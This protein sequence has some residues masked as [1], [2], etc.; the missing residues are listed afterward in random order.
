MIELPIPDLGITNSASIEVDYPVSWRVSDVDADMQTIK[1]TWTSNE[2]GAGDTIVTGQSTGVY[3]ARFKSG[4]MK[5][6]TMQVEDK[7]GGI[8]VARYYYYVTPSKMVYV[9]PY[10]PYRSGPLSQISGQYA[11]ASGRGEGRVWSDGTV[12]VTDFEHKYRFGTSDTTAKL[13][14]WGYKNGQSD[15]GYLWS[16][17]MPWGPN[18]HRDHPV[19]ANGNLKAAS[20]SPE[21]TN[22]YYVYSDKSG[23]D[24]F[25]YAWVLCTKGE[26]SAVFVGTPLVAPLNPAAGDVAANYSLALPLEATDDE[27]NPVFQDSFVE[28]FFAKEKYASDN[29]GDMNGDGIPDY[30]ATKSW[31]DPSGAL[32]TLPEAQT[33]QS[34]S[35]SAGDA[36]S[37]SYP[38]DLAA[39]DGYNGDADFLPAAWGSANPL[40]PQT[41][42][43]GPGQKFTAIRE[44]RGFGN[45]LNEP[46][47][48][49]YDLTEAETNAL[50]AA[51]AAAGE[52]DFTYAA[53]TNWATRAGWTPEAIN[54]GT[55][56]RL[57][58]I[59]PDTDG[60]EFNDGWEYY[61]WYYAKIGAMVD[62]KWG[63]LEGRRLDIDGSSSRITPEE[64]AQA[65]DPHAARDM[66]GRFGMDFDNDGLTDL[67]E[68]VLG[69]NPCDWD[70]DGDG[71]SDLWEV[72][73][74]VDPCFADVDSNPD[75][76]FMARLDYQGDTF[77]LYAFANG[78]MYALP[79]ATASA[80]AVEAA[81]TAQ[82]VFKVE[83]ADADATVAYWS[84]Q[85]PAVYSLEDGSTK[86]A[87]DLEC[88]TT[89]TLD[90]DYLGA[91]TCLS[92][93]TVV[94]V[95]DQPEQKT[96]GKATGF[97]WI[98][99]GTQEKGTTTTALKVF[100][101]GGDGAT[102]VPCASGITAYAEIPSD[103]ELVE[104]RKK[105]TITL[106][107]DQVYTH[108]G[109]DPR[110][111]WN[112]DEYGLL[113]TRWKNPNAEEAGDYGDAGRPMNTVAYTTRDEYLLLQY[114]RQ[115]LPDDYE[116]GVGSYVDIFRAH[117]TYPNLP[118]SFID[119]DKL[120]YKPFTFTNTTV[121]AYWDSLRASSD[122]D[123]GVGQ[124][125]TDIHGAD[126][127]SDGVPDGW[128]LYVGTNPLDELDGGWHIDSDVLSLAQEFA[129]VDSCSAYT[130][131][132]MGTMLVYPEVYSITKNH[133]GKTSSWWNKLFP[134]DPRSNDTDGDGLADDKERG[135]WSGTFYVGNNDYPASFS[136]MY[137]EYEHD[138]GAVCFRGG[139][140]NP[141]T[142]DTDGDL[143]P[144]PW[145]YEFAGIL[146]TGDSYSISPPAR[147]SNADRK[148]LEVGFAYRDMATNT[149]AHIR[150]GMDGTFAGD[151]NHD[152]DN[153]GLANFQEYLVQTL[154]HL[155]YDDSLTPLMGV[156][157]TTKKFVRFIPFSAWD[158]SAFHKKCTENGF[159]GSGAWQFSKLGYFALP[160]HSWDLLVH[161]DSSCDNYAH[162]EGAG[163]RI[164]FPPS[165]VV[166]LVGTI[167]ASGYA[168]TDP[169]RIDT[170]NDGMDDFY[171]LFHGLNPLL[172][173]AADPLSI[174]PDGSTSCQRYD[175]IARLYGGRVN[176]WANHWTG[177]TSVGQPAFDAIRHPWMIGT[178]ECDADGDGMR[179]DEESIKVNLALPRNTHTDPTPLWMTD[180]TSVRFASF[181]SQYYLPDPY[182]AETPNYVEGS[183]QPDIFRYPWTDFSSTTRSLILYAAEGD[184][185]AA[186]VL[187]QGTGGMDRRW[188]FSFEENEGYDTD[189]D[190]RPDADEMTGTTEPTSDPL[191]YMDV[192]RR[193]ALYLPGVE[194]AAVSYDSESRREVGSEPDMLKQFTVE[195]WICPEEVVA[196]SV[197]LERVSVYGPSTLSNDQTYVRANFRL[198]IDAEGRVYGEYEGSTPDYGANR[199]T[200]AQYRPQPG[201]WM[202]LALAYDGSTLA[203]Y[204][205]GELSP[206]EY[207]SN[208]RQLPA[209]GVD[210]VLQYPNGAVVPYEGYRALP[211]ANIIG[212]RAKTKNAISIDE[213][214]QWTDFANHYKGWI[215]EIRVW[216][217]ARMP[218][219]I[220]ADYKKRYSFDDVAKNREAVYMLWKNGG[221][222]ANGNLP[223]EILFHYNFV[224]LPG[225]V[226][227]G[228]VLKTPVGFESKVLD[229]VRKNGEDIYESL[230][231][232]W[233]SSLGVRSNVYSPMYVPWMPN[234]V[235]HMPMFDGSTA[236]SRYWSSWSAGVVDMM[237][238]YDYPN[239]CNPYV[240]Y[241]YRYEKFNRLIQ[242]FFMEQYSV[243]NMNVNVNGAFE[244]YKFQLRSDFVG[245]SDLVP[246]GGAF[247][248]RSTNF[249]DGAG[250]MDA[251]VLTAKNEYTPADS[252]GDGIPDWAEKLGFTDKEEY[253]R[254]LAAGLLPDAT[255]KDDVN[256]L[257]VDKADSNHDGLLDWWQRLY[258]LKGIASEDSDMDG[259]ADFAEYLVSDKFKFANVSP[260]KTRTNGSEFD[261]FLKRGKLYLG[262]MFSDHD[263]MEDW[264]EALY[265]DTVVDSA[266]YDPLG[267]S[268]LDGWSNYAECRA[269]T[270]PN[271][272]STIVID[273]DE[274]LEYPVPLITAN[275]YYSKA[276]Q[277]AAPVVINAY[278][279]RSSS[280]PDAT[281]V[282]SGTAEEKEYEIALGLNP[283]RKHT[284]NIGRNV[285]PGT[286]RVSLSHPA[287]YGD[288]LGYSGAWYGL[289]FERPN[290]GTDTADLILYTI[291]GLTGDRVGTVNYY[292]G[293]YEIDFSLLT[294]NVSC[295]SDKQV[296]T[297]FV[298][299]GSGFDLKSS[300][301]KIAWKSIRPPSSMPWQFKLTK[302]ESGHVREGLNTFEVY[303]DLDNSG[304]Y[305]LGEPHGFVRGVDV[306]WNSCSFDVELKD[307]SSALPRVDLGMGDD[308]LAL[309]RLTQVN[310]TRVAI[311][312][313][314][315]SANGIIVNPK[316]KGFDIGT[317]GYIYECDM[318]GANEFDLDWERFPTDVM[319]SSMVKNG[320]LQV[321]SVT[322][323]VEVRTKSDVSD[324]AVSNTFDLVRRFTGVHHAPTPVNV[325]AVNYGARPVFR[326]KYDSAV[327]Q[328]DWDTF[329]SFSVQVKQGSA[330]IWNSG[331]RMLPPRLPGGEF[332]WVAPICVNDLLSEGKMFAN[333]NNYT[334][335]V[336]LHN[337]KF[338][339]DT[340][341]AEQSFRMNVYGENEPNATG[342]GVA[343]LRVKYFGPASF[344]TSMKMKGAVRV[345]AYPTPDFTGDPLGATVVGSSAHL[346]DSVYGADAVN[347]TIIGL[348][349]GTYYVCAYID[350]NGNRKR[351]AFESWGYV[352]PRGD[353]VTKAIFNPL[354]IKVGDG[355]AVEETLYIEDVDTDQDCLPDVWEYDQAQGVDGFLAKK[356][357]SANTHNGYISVNPELAAAINNML[358]GSTTAYMLSA[359]LASLPSD[360]VALSL[361]IDTAENTIEASTV[362]VRAISLAD[363]AVNLTIG[364]KA[365]EPDLGKLYVKDNTV[366]ATI[367]V[368]SAASL[369]GEWTPSYP[370]TKTFT[371][372]DDDVNDVFTFSLEELGL[373]ASKKGFFKVE[374]K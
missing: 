31:T 54:P 7:D 210:G 106:I 138:T 298:N 275:V 71:A 289:L 267:D 80:P 288:G 371:I 44:I 36:G 133:P 261:Y 60:D 147:L 366:T 260:V 205:N 154:R 203:M 78:E 296:V 67:E 228:N 215:D 282:L 318:M 90:T 108:E 206:V 230:V 297:G 125:S 81:G 199:V 118:I 225:G 364:A 83:V 281:W 24:S 279:R 328:D 204:V 264:W 207:S 94:T 22:G 151:A 336:S 53:A 76:D 21:N 313:I 247:A 167:N 259:L 273:S 189:R 320:Y 11:E 284:G 214:T 277:T 177:W 175:V 161:S 51:Y 217:G 150:G 123:A 68:Y 86:L 201:T 237:T 64:I 59:H 308:P 339:T 219:D 122:T 129:G 34:I 17:D 13:Y 74:G 255:A 186:E 343:N 372:E 349:S 373:D 116:T 158:G 356:N 139:G 286:V 179:N 361:G 333:T 63:R 340:W 370:I 321:T 9:H 192:N 251:W 35:G 292:T 97:S 242:L 15:N 353:T 162:S 72:M 269:G 347:A 266:K 56:T 197:I 43:W 216:D 271:R 26:D 369:D 362:A 330:A 113:G 254:A 3:V 302:T 73:M 46:G 29:M 188:M 374:L 180:S 160:P 82:E 39:V 117:T 218:A 345:E 141:C 327:S 270:M 42:N 316:L 346:T 311:D 69:T 359:G 32:K 144:D 19:G 285:V 105:V 18:T 166:P 256:G 2:A 341:S 278:S 196:D 136:F 183:T 84:L 245:S 134:T 49:D 232:G 152:Y 344:N 307:I 334:W 222:R 121:M 6:L 65:F 326:W 182:I 124:N 233:W 236:D 100:N 12:N 250:A 268:D 120:S 96:S 212:A 107:H 211:C 244:K 157:P 332:E 172:G 128:E 276:D 200:C 98:D 5:T 85:K 38:P 88:Y 249:W 368:W 119:A 209:N 227:A 253:L 363:G 174:T 352:C 77:T 8:S 103:S 324:L 317:R 156:D 33:G 143:L 45:G 102:Y 224:T 238:P 155:R 50:F 104:V 27:I 263:F 16:K 357:P 87:S 290:P 358:S 310:V 337:S 52:T 272:T 299:D 127:D 274:Y 239:T 309:S 365:N 184:D 280:K 194:S 115:V 300:Y 75:R 191:N 146:K 153:D 114:R 246:L 315:S 48:S 257:Y 176:A 355:L 58:P 248:R 109:F 66:G 95:A 173:S 55:G 25:F 28:A 130:N 40:N 304:T 91:L 159:T 41:K 229:N 165:A 93:G 20:G 126:T 295:N 231:V 61:F 220:R 325:N 1:V 195:C 223:P 360:I 140:L 89:L 145:E 354:A 181:T 57:N 252:D 287:D 164:M 306:K 243:T 234:T 110:V 202:H 226:T 178:M 323:R 101:Y 62:G 185:V 4:G 312:G 187:R 70:S 163:Y 350:S 14:A 329:T 190:F 47:V 23:R 342:Y 338:Q 319:K 283:G 367:V 169:R 168:C 221:T 148:S 235:A 240:D 351:D 135:K 314:S 37:S 301:F 137:R 293:D 291:D 112:I 213:E 265:P 322:Y 149:V 79:S 198:G 132:Y 348:E 99:P 305:S 262:E 208:T 142:V 111:A 171:E 241:V 294:Q 335:A 331:V 170:D 193:Q 30:F 303:L 131:R 258:D 92:A 10:G